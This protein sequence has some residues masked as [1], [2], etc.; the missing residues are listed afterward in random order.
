MVGDRR[1]FCFKRVGVSPVSSSAKGGIHRSTLLKQK[2]DGHRP[3]LH[4][5]FPLFTNHFREVVAQL[6]FEPRTR[7]FSIY[8]STN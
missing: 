6:G 4:L 3:P 1:F 8:C 5:L 7:K 2:S